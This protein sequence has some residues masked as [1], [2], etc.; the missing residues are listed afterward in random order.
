MVPIKS[1]KNQGAL[2]GLLGGNVNGCLKEVSFKMSFKRRKGLR[3][4][5]ISCNLGKIMASEG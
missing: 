3:V 1:K 2:R 5:N 4:S